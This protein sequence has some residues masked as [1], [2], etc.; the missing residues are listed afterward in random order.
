VLTN[1]AA[2]GSEYDGEV[3]TLSSIQ[4]RLRLLEELTP[5]AHDGSRLGEIPVDQ[6]AA[7][8][9]QALVRWI[10]L[11]APRIALEGPEGPAELEAMAIGFELVAAAAPGNA[12]LLRTLGYLHL[13]ERR[14]EDARAAF[15]SAAELPPEVESERGPERHLDLARMYV[16]MEAFVD[17]IHEVERGLALAP[18]W[19]RT[20]DA[21][22]EVHEQALIGAGRRDEALVVLEQRAIACD[23]S[24]E[25]HHRLARERIARGDITGAGAAL[26]R[27]ASLRSILPGDSS[28]EQRLSAS[29][30]PIIAEL[31]RARRDHEGALLEALVDRIR[32]AN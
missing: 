25:L 9:D 14:W 2:P 7:W 32:F 10:V 31:H 21:L 5:H 16:S 28:F 29:F 26:E 8:L 20:Q 11:A 23:F 27:A 4:D 19:Y 18:R 1:D 13:R 6:Q 12:E 24:L 15:V 3:S 22:R 17:A 30:E